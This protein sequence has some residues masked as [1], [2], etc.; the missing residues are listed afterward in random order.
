MRDGDPLLV[1]EAI[2]WA[3]SD[4]N[5]KGELGRSLDLLIASRGYYQGEV[6]TAA[7][8]IRK[9]VGMYLESRGRKAA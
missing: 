1:C 5:L 6:V 8:A 9:A 2:Q 7:G 4:P 3:L